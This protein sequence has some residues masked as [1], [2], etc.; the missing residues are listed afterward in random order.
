[1]HANWEL[2]RLYSC[3]WQCTSLCYYKGWL[4][5]SNCWESTKK[6]FS[7]CTNW[8]A[9]WSFKCI[10][11]SIFTG[12]FLWT[13]LESSLVMQ[14]CNMIISIVFHRQINFAL[15]IFRFMEIS[16][17]NN[18]TYNLF[19]IVFFVISLWFS[20]FFV[21][22]CS[23]FSYSSF[24]ILSIVNTSTSKNTCFKFF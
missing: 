17:Q 21:V 19:I 13:L 20:C 18:W 23:L 3:T 1:M 7:I 9:S 6:L 8:I 22:D 24:S 5:L 11:L 14:N 4:D 10:L 2:E 15:Y 16:S 12:L